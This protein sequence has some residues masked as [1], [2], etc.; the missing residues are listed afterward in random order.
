VCV[1]LQLPLPVTLLGAA[2]PAHFRVQV[3]EEQLSEQL[4]VQVTAQ[5]APAPQE[6]LPLL[7]SVAVQFD[8]SHETLPLAP[9]VKLHVLP[10]LQLLLQEP[11]QVPVQVL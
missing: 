8:A 1:Q 10:A 2:S 5:V 4:P 7:P 11:A 3:E 9:T 6:M